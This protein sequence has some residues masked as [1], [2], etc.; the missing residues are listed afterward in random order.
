MKAA[1]I[2]SLI[3]SIAVF[4]CR[5][6]IHGSIGFQPGVTGAIASTKSMADKIQGIWGM[7]GDE[8]A[9]FVIREDKIMYPEID[10]GYRYYLK[11]DSITIKYDEYERAFALHIQGTDTLILTG[12]EKRVYY[13]YRHEG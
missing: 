4:S 3:L 1:I 7:A 13:R 2:P 12:N 11:N 5:N 6:A 9:S 8:T 10:A